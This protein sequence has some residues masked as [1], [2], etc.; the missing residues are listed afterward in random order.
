VVARVVEGNTVVARTSTLFQ[1]E[2]SVISSIPIRQKISLRIARTSMR[3][4]DEDSVMYSV[5]VC[6]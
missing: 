2:D 1:D 3:L 6:K 4:C 5:P